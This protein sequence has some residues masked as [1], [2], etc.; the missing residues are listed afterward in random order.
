MIGN[1]LALVNAVTV[2]SGN[3]LAAKDKKQKQ[4]NNNN[5]K[6]QTKKKPELCLR[7]KKYNT[8]EYSEELYPQFSPPKPST[9]GRKPYPVLYS[10][11][12]EHLLSQSTYQE[13]LVRDFQKRDKK[14]SH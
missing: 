5:N 3:I 10:Y 12:W 1:N 13:V 9:T 2:M 14:M 7:K 4:T 11:L 6:K 8:K